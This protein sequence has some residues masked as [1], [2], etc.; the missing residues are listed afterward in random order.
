[1]NTILITGCNRGIGLELVSQYASDGWRVYATCRAPDAAEKLHALAGQH[2]SI[3]VH[4][5]NVANQDDIRALGN[6][7][8][9]V[10]IDVLLNNAGI[11]ASQGSRFGNVD[12]NTWLQA[13]EINTIAP[14]LMA[15]AFIDQ[16]QSGRRKVIATVSSKVGSIS[17]NTS[18]GGYAYR[19]SKSA[20][21]HVMKCLAIDLASRG[22]KT[23]TLHPGWVRTDMGGP[24]ALIDTQTSVSGMKKV[25][26]DLT[27]DQSGLFFNYDGTPI[28][29]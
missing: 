14:L 3:S 22:I 12:K 25:I 17:D 18:G 5:L 20:V 13:I 28:P 10:R 6:K 19:S 16:V 11:Y 21:N 8:A 27:K 15:Q 9:G 2:S 23:V 7:L 4:A 1:M 29:W 26:N 24:N